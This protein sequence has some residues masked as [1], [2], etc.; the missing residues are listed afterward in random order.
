MSAVN[1]TRSAV[2]LVAVILAVLLLPPRRANAD[3]Q[4]YSGLADL[5][6]FSVGGAVA[7]ADV[8]IGLYD[9]HAS[10]SDQRISKLAA[11][12]QLALMVPQLVFGTFAL[13]AWAGQG[14]LSGDAVLIGLALMTIPLSLAIHDIYVLATP[15]P[16]A[17]LT[18]RLEIPKIGGIERVMLSPTAISLTQAAG[19][20]RAFK[21]NQSTG[22]VQLAPGVALAFRF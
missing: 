22:S 1:P 15:D 12:I 3:G 19:P 21:T 17:S 13:S 16:K 7:L 18:A 6:V 2:I 14:S 20:A 5:Y 10:A 8:G 9:I 11:A 4:G